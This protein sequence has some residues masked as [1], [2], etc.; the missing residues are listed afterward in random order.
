[1]AEV[2]LR[3]QLHGPH[4]V[5]LSLFLY[6]FFGSRFN[7][8]CFFP[9]ATTI[10]IVTSIIANIIIITIIVIQRKLRRNFRVTAT[11]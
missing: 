8:L 11:N 2:D 7:L 9:I 5:S 1:M 10:I 6:L 3:Q 4:L